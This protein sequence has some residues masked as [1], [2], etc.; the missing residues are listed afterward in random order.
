MEGEGGVEGEKRSLDRSN[1]GEAVF[2][3]HVVLG[4]CFIKESALL[5]QLTRLLFYFYFY[6]YCYCYC[7]ALGADQV[8]VS[9]SC[10][11]S[12]GANILLMSQVSNTLDW[13]G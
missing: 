3:S 13:N 11:S 9:A 12:K 7:I 6:C 10:A 2:A 4:C 5:F 8:F 1:S